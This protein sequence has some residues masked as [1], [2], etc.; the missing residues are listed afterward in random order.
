MGVSTRD[1]SRGHEQLIIA[2]ELIKSGKHAN[3]LCLYFKG[4]TDRS[5]PRMTEGGRGWRGV[6]ERRRSK[7]NE[8]PRGIGYKLHVKMHKTRLWSI[9]QVFTSRGSWPVSDQQ[10]ASERKFVIYVWIVRLDTFIRRIKVFKQLQ[11]EE[12]NRVNYFFILFPIYLNSLAKEIW[13][14][15][16]WISFALLKGSRS[17]R[18]MSCFMQTSKMADVVWIIFPL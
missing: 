8:P 6:P 9:N 7:G 15:L 18:I 1:H 13:F 10:S 4:T 17:T 16:I 11:N 2:S 12:S 14:Y 3:A 5:Q